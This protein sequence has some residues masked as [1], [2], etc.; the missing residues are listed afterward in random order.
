ML[1][2]SRLIS[3]PIFHGILA[4]SRAV[5][6]RKSL[7]K[8]RMFMDANKLNFLGAP[9][10]AKQLGI[11]PGREEKRALILIGKVRSWKRFLFFFSPVR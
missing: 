11:E 4:S 8:Y 7:T 3:L 5:D 10:R 2:A 9:R 6:A 1:F